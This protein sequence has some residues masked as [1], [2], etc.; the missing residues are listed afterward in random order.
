MGAVVTSPATVFGTF[1]FACL[2]FVRFCF[3]FTICL[4]DFG[5]LVGA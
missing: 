1:P 5:A 2:L 3:V 4:L